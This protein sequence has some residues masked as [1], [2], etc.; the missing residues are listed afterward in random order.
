MVHKPTVGQ[1]F[2]ELFDRQP[3]WMIASLAEQLHYSI[4]SVRRFLASIGYFSSFT[5]NGKWYTLSSIPRF[6]RDGLWF[7]QEIGFS[8]AGTLPRTLIRLT[9]RSPA[10]MTSE[11]LKEKL[12]CRCH[13]VLVQLCRKG[14]LDRF[15]QGRSYVYLAADPSTAAIQRQ[16]RAQP[17]ELSPLPAQMA[18]FV[19]AEVV[20]APEAGFGQLSEAVFQR[21][22]VRIEIPQIEAL[23]D[24]HGLKKTPHIIGV[25]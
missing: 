11:Q 7:H 18:V 23:L 13:G 4:P 25:Q 21:T 19:L 6:G 5:H 1:R 2:T 8:R 20:R 15:K 3:C 14:M 22:G 12:R 24:R 17:K 16:A 9:E 10:G